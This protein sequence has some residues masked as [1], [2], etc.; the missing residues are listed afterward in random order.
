[1]AVN[2]KIKPNQLSKKDYCCGSFAVSDRPNASEYTGA[3]NGTGNV[4]I[5]IDNYPCK[6]GYIGGEFEV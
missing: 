5:L 2:H 3:K 6:V 4:Y 1:M